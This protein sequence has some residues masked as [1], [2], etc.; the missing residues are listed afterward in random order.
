MSRERRWVVISED[1]RH[2]TLG[3]HTDPSEDEIKTAE[4]AL[5]AS[6]TAGWLAVTEG[7]YY[8]EDAMTVLQVRTLGTPEV[9][10]DAASS[11]F[12]ALRNAA[13]EPPVSAT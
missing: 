7:V 1:G 9:T 2:A 11:R 12:L 3:R 13:N 4:A 10:W 6:G 8:S 5:T